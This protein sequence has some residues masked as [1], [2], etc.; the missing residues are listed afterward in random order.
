[1]FKNGKGG[2]GVM[3]PMITASSFEN[4]DYLRY[5]RKT[6]SNPIAMNMQWEGRC[7]EAPCTNEFQLL[8]ID[9]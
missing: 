1:M 6:S 8:W 9:S 7:V 5:M 2:G 3:P 4:P